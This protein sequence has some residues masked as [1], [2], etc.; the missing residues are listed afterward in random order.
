MWKKDVSGNGRHIYTYLG[1]KDG[2][3][4][5]TTVHPSRF[6]REYDDLTVGL[7]RGWHRRLDR[8]GNLFFFVDDNTQ[9][10]TPLDL[11][12]N[13]SIDQDTGLPNGWCCTLVKDDQPKANDSLKSG[14]KEP[15]LIPYY[16]THI[17]KT[18]IG[19]K[20]PHA[21]LS[22]SLDLKDFLASEPMQGEAII[23]DVTKNKFSY[24]GKI[25]VDQ[26]PGMNAEQR[27]RYYKIF[28]EVVEKGEMKLGKYRITRE[29]A[30]SRCRDSG[31]PAA[32]YI[33][34]ILEAD[35]NR[36]GISTPPEFAQVLHAMSFELK[37]WQKAQPIPP[38]AQNQLLKYDEAFEKYKSMENLEISVDEALT[39][40]SHMYPR[41][42]VEFANAMWIK[43]AKDTHSENA[44]DI[45]KFGEGMHRLQVELERR[46]GETVTSLRHRMRW[47][48]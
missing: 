36:D 37:A 32:V 21:I 29:Q 7:P 17:G 48:C 33:P 38:P 26:L 3:P 14:E 18:L 45:V 5:D 8:D 4:M 15:R 19:T 11:R 22:K 43:K 35:A 31:L 30:E 10:A 12:F 40:T 41:S 20:W 39:A 24:S 28:S 42:L 25:R 27:N 47:C 6:Y 16:Y 1:G 13:R 46:K 44:L 9:S 34:I 23:F 2:E